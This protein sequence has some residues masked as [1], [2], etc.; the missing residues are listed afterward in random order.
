VSRADGR[1]I[2]G[3]LCTS[4]DADACKC[5][6]RCGFEK[7]SSRGVCPGSVLLAVTSMITGTMLKM[8]ITD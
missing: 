2:G 4:V 5:F 3:V 6:C 8:S 7:D 1:G